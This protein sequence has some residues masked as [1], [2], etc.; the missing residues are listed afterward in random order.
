[1][2]RS[3]TSSELTSRMSSHPA[4]PP[5]AW[6]EMPQRCSR[7]RVRFA[8]PKAGAPL[9]PALRCGQ[10]KSATG[11]SG[12]MNTCIQGGLPQRPALEPPW[13]AAMRTGGRYGEQSVTDVAGLKCYPCPRPFKICE[14]VCS[15]GRHPHRT[16]SFTKQLQARHR[17]KERAGSLHKV[18]LILSLIHI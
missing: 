13:Y 2:R 4:G 12:G 5:V 6:P 8:A 7:A 15:S 9:R 16:D 18:E 10:S 3:Q 14:R 11:G 1:M 17:G